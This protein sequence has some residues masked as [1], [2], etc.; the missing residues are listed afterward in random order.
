MEWSNTSEERINE[1]CDEMFKQMIIRTYFENKS[2][3]I[4]NTPRHPTSESVRCFCQSLDEIDVTKYE[5]AP[6]TT[7][8]DLCEETCVLQIVESEGE[9]EL[10]VIETGNTVSGNLHGIDNVNFESTDD[11]DET[12]AKMA[13]S[14]S[15]SDTRR[16]EGDIT[17]SGGETLNLNDIQLFPLLSSTGE[18]TNQ[19][20][21]DEELC[22]RDEKNID[23]ET[24]AKT[25]V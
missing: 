18:S 5:P 10:H 6:S 21:Q 8:T 3:P 17:L 2:A 12:H 20:S 14:E 22:F 23:E 24:Y 16:V 15:H 25:C 7:D 1:W 19:I 9:S 4:T 13:Q 11:A